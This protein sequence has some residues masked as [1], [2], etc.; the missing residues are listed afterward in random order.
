VAK[1]II[2]RQLVAAAAEA[3]LSDGAEPSIINV[4][5]RIGG[6]SYTTVKRYL[7]QWREEHSANASAAPPLPPEIEAKAKDFTR[8]LWIGANAIAEEQTASARA[9]A[10]AEIAAM[11]QDLSDARGEIARLEAAEAEQSEQLGAAEARLRETE[12]RLAEANTRAGRLA[13]T[14]NDL[15]ALRNELAGVRHEA[16]DQARIAAT[17]TG[18]ADALKAELQRLIT[19]F[20][21]PD[22]GRAG[23]KTNTGKG[24]KDSLPPPRASAA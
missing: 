7:D 4:K 20:A 16:K 23:T 17:K 19:G 3:P 9:R 5:A 15:K 24:K 10:D 13:E 2:T 18:E 22:N 1:A 21:S 8:H 11:R 14:E 6:G 12:L